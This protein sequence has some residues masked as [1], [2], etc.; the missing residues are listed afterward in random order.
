MPQPF[1]YA[2]RKGEI[3]K[4][5]D[6]ERSKFRRDGKVQQIRHDVSAQ[7]LAAFRGL[8]AIGYKDK[9]KLFSIHRDEVFPPQI[10]PEEI[11]L[12]WQAGKVAKE[13]VKRELEEAITNE[14][15]N[16]VAI[17]K[18]G[19][20]FFVLAIMGVLLH[21]RNG[22]TFLNKLKPEV[23]A[24]KA[25]TRRLENYATISLEWHVE[26]MMELVAAGE[27]VASIVRSQS[28]WQK[29]KPKIASRWKVYRLAR[30]VMEES[31]PRL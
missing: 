27:D 20:A 17:L 21:E 10:R 5:T 28:G 14:D 1:F 26:F 8:P 31:L 6:T 12:V 22:Q 23:A 24:S 29:I 7:F 25:T 13:L 11:V 9:G 3:Q 4:L 19:A 16:R 2:L 15:E 18:R 30:K